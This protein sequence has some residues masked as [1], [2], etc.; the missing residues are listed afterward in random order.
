M[1]FP[2]QVDGKFHSVIAGDYKNA[3]SVHSKHKDA[4]RA[5]VDWFADDSGYATTQ[6]GV[7]PL[8]NGPPSTTLT[9][10]N[11]L[12]VQYLELNPAPTGK[13][14]LVNDIDKESNILVFSP[15][16]WQA[17]VDDARSGKVTKQAYFDSLDKKWAAALKTTSS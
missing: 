16:S 17:M 3:I 2:V 5:W 7:S 9:D 15:P 8:L 4:A 6:G 13:E 12:G 10:F 14:S 1:P 11:T